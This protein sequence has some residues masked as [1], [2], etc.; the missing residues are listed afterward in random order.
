MS[1]LQGQVNSLQHV[2]ETLRREKD[3]MAEA[4][5]ELKRKLELA[6]VQF[7]DMDMECQ[8][9]VVGEVLRGIWVCVWGGG[10]HRGMGMSVR[11]GTQ[12]YVRKRYS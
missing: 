4:N 2:V 1:D 5:N 7:R 12:G 11:G 3:E 9:Y 10:T 8:R 6:E